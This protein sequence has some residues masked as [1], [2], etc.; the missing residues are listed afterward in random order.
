M[1]KKLFL[2]RELP[3][4]LVLLFLLALLAGIGGNP[5]LFF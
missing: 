5:K 3:F 4:N 2:L 1:T